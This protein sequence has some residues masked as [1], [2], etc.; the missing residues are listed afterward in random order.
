MV[1]RNAIPSKYPLFLA[2]WYKNWYEIYCGFGYC[3]LTLWI[4]P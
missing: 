4:G 1:W 2:D 3:F